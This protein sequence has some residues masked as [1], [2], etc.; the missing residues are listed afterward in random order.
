MNLLLVDDE[1]ITR[2]GII[3]KLPW[4]SLGVDKIEQA[5]DGIHAMEAAERL[6][7]DILLT[8]VR[9]PRMNGTELAYKIRER[10]PNCYIIFMSGYTDKEY[11]KAAINVSATAYVE[12]PIDLEELHSAIEK[13]VFLSGEEKKLA[14]LKSKLPLFS[15]ANSDE[16]TLTINVQESYIQK[17]RMRPIVTDILKYIDLHYQDVGLSL[18]QVAQ[19]MYLTPSHICVI[20]KDETH[21]TINQHISH[22]RIE[23][24]KE[25]LKD[26][27]IKVKEVAAMVGYHDSNYFAKIFKKQTGFTP[28]EYRELGIQ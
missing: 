11:M 15:L 7:P 6:K 14:V 5:D 13:A 17:A 8:D 27:R 21:S 9:M 3:E 10:Y 19:H 22:L 23:K 28:L 2:E 24:A 1:W 16:Q 18:Q 20:F 25:M 4:D 12:K 26:N